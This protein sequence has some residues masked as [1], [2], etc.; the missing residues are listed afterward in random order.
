MICLASK[1]IFT[2]CYFELTNAIVERLEL[3]VS[4]ATAGIEINDRGAKIISLAWATLKENKLWRI[5]Y[6]HIVILES[7]I[8]FQQNILLIIKRHDTSDQRKL[9]DVK[10]IGCRR[11]MDFPEAFPFNIQSSRWSKHLL[12]LL[13]RLSR[14]VDCDTCVNLLC[15]AIKN[16]QSTITL[17]NRT[18][19]SSHLTAADIY[20]ALNK[21]HEGLLLPCTQ[22]AEMEADIVSRDN[23]PKRSILEKILINEAS[24]PASALLPQPRRIKRARR[25]ATPE[26]DKQSKVLDK[27]AQLK[28]DV[29][30]SDLLLQSGR[31]TGAQR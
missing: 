19:S 30:A 17:R 20:R 9:K 8:G 21:V 4:I 29:P 25:Q 10:Q 18:R 3:P 24:V 5:K 11:K 12:T 13:A 7:N 1:W 27:L 6:Y 28:Q 15:N 2:A 14:Y 22:T 16:R 26:K 31:I 23:L